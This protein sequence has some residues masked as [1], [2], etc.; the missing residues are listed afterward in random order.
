M[1]GGNRGARESRSPLLLPRPASTVDPPRCVFT[2]S[3]LLVSG[4]RGDNCSRGDEKIP[5]ADRGLADSSAFAGGSGVLLCVAATRRH[6]TVFYPR[7]T[8]LLC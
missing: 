4:D 5:S 1:R 8:R 3:A 6:Q 7:P 2:C